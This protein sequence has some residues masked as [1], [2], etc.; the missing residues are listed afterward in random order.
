[1]TTPLYLEQY[2]DSLQGLPTDLSKNLSELGELDRGCQ[3]NLYQ[4]DAKVKRLVKS[5]RNTSRDARKKQYDE[6]KVN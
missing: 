3:Q 5:W 1:M 6:I 4:V 2:L